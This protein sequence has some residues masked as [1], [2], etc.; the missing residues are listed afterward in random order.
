MGKGNKDKK[1]K[2]KKNG[3]GKKKGEILATPLGKTPTYTKGMDVQDFLDETEVKSFE[4]YGCIMFAAPEE[5]MRELFKEQ[6]ASDMSIPEDVVGKVVDAFVELEHPKRGFKYIGGRST[7]EECRTVIQRAMEV[8]QTFHIFALENGK[9]CTFDPSPELIEDE[10]FREQQLNDIIRSKK[11]GEQRSKDFFRG[12]MR[13]KVDKARLE[14][15]KEGQKLLLE[16]EEP[17]QAVQF[18][19]ESA[20]KNIAELKEKIAEQERTH[21]LAQQKLEQMRSEG[22]DKAE[23]AE[24]QAAEMEAKM[25]AIDLPERPAMEE[26]KHKLGD[27]AQI[28]SER[29]YPED[30]ARATAERMQDAVN[31]PEQPTLDQLEPAHPNQ[32]LFESGII[33]PAAIR[34]DKEE[35]DE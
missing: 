6:I 28:E 35:K 10:N 22:K 25:Q 2:K 14:G 19:A 15:T 18:R 33:I 4:K 31:P 13:K 12:E 30:L 8:D 17:Y 3:G 34:A 32:G 9:W 29:R 20:L 23:F 27:L 26:I 21:E 5:S 7:L 24:K 11:V 16:A 1:N